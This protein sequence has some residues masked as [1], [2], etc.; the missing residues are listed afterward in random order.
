[1]GT[2]LFR[3]GEPIKGGRWF[4]RLHRRAPTN[5]DIVSDWIAEMSMQFGPEKGDW[6]NTA[7]TLL[8]ETREARP[9]DARPLVTLGELFLR[10]NRPADAVR[11][12]ERALERSR[13]NPAAWAGHGKAIEILGRLTQAQESYR[14]ALCLQPINVLAAI[15]VAVRLIAE[16][17]H[18][19]AIRILAPGLRVFPNN[20]ELQI[21]S[22]RAK[23]SMELS[24]NQDTPLASSGVAAT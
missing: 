21:L 23:A 24:K 15:G 13:G 19:E 5:F 1:M 4:E 3:E 14:R 18:D 10:K 11:K 8:D 22:L 7:E 12:F 17:K 9:H 20:R 2:L 6:W 16:G